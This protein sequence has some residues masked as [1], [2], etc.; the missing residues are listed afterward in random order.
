MNKQLH[1]DLEI[2]QIKD[3]RFAEKTHVADH[4]LYIDKQEML[5]F[6]HDP[7]FLDLDIALARPGESVRII[8]VKD[9]VEPRIKM[10]E[11][12]GSFPGFFGAVEECGEGTTKVLRGCAV[13]TTGTV[14][15]FQE[16]F[17]DM[18][19]VASEYTQ[20]SKLNNVVVN[21]KAPEDSAPVRREEAMRIL[22]LKAAHYLALATKETPADYCES[23]EL[24]EV[25]PARKL[26]RVAIVTLTMCQG[27]LH[28][29]YLYGQDVKHLNTTL[30]HPNEY[31]DGAMVN[32]TCVV[33]SDKYTTWDYQNNPMIK[34]LYDRHGKE[35]EFCGCIMTPTYVVLA[36][37][38]RC[39]AAAV[40]IATMLHLD[41][42]LVPEE[43]GGNP[44]AD[45]MMVI[46][47]CEAKGIRTVGLMTPLGGVEGIGDTAE[48]A[49]AMIATGY[50]GVDFV[51]EAMDTVIGDI[52]Q[53]AVLTGGFP[54]SL[55][56]DGSMYINILAITGAHNQM[57]RH[58]LCSKVL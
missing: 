35:L 50:E 12:G 16:G 15:A 5:E 47:G 11:K 51:V 6:I 32:G 37:K 31:M 56:P 19:G 33:A 42:V 1:L 39:T 46:R 3:V 38:R 4:V 24:T 36:D 18:R 28:D 27:L 41:G 54:D 9:V 48:E 45:L 2:V 58:N 7:F 22:G 53:I 40:R 55:R 44:E 13:V 25:D 20:F 49:D 23:Y 34:E 52:E 8:P 17:I 43:G 30:L 26:P 21:A 57:G 29:N 10:S 14:V